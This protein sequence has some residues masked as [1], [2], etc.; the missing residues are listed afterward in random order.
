MTFAVKERKK[1]IE[2]PI[3]LEPYESYCNRLIE[4]THK[5]VKEMHDIVHCKDC[6]FWGIEQDGYCAAIDDPYMLETNADDFCSWGEK[7]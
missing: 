5:M 2:M 3:T 1:M 4:E 7:R 6:R